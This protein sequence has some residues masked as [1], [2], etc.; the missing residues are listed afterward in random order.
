VQSL[1]CRMY[2]ERSLS[3]RARIFIGGRVFRY[4]RAWWREDV[5]TECED[6][7][8]YL[9]RDSSSYHEFF[10]LWSDNSAK[11]PFRSEPSKDKQGEAR[12]DGCSRK[13]SHFKDIF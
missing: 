7:L 2:Q 6:V 4:R 5:H 8:H 9:T 1:I 11:M 12:E 3:G 13:G 10:D